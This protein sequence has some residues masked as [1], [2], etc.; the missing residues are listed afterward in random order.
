MADTGRWNSLCP[1][2]LYYST[3]LMNALIFILTFKLFA[4]SQSGLT[5]N[6]NNREICRNNRKVLCG[7]LKRTMGDKLG[8]ICPSLV[9]SWLINMNRIWRKYH[10]L[11]D[12]KFFIVGGNPATLISFPSL[13]LLCFLFWMFHS[14]LFFWYIGPVGHKKGKCSRWSMTYTPLDMQSEHIDYPMWR[15]HMVGLISNNCLNFVIDRWCNC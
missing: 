10:I 9:R 12:Y 3:L 13:V 8:I 15:D 14:L 6:R 4:I 7:L 5:S 1:W 11:N 2:I